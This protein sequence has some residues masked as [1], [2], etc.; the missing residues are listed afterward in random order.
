MRKFGNPSDVSVVGQPSD[1]LHM[2]RNRAGTRCSRDSLRIQP[3]VLEGLGRVVAADS[4]P[5]T[6]RYGEAARPRSTLGTRRSSCD[7]G[8]C[9]GSGESRDPDMRLCT[10]VSRDGC[11]YERTLAREQPSAGQGRCRLP[12]GARFRRSRR[13]RVHANVPISYGTLRDFAPDRITQVPLCAAC[14]VAGSCPSL[15]LRLRLG[16]PT[17]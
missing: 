16:T 1:R 6:G 10:T 13:C 4:V 9:G 3:I 11:R 8:N 17:R 15:P 12:P 2:F 14:C 7:A 5:W